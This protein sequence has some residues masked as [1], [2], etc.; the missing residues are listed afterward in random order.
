[1]NRT[2]CC[3]RVVELVEVD[4]GEHISANPLAGLIALALVTARRLPHINVDGRAPIHAFEFTLMKRIE[5]WESAIPQAVTS[6]T[7]PRGMA[8]C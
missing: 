5:G 7:C 8:L 1:M 6:Q 2:C 4:V 3:I